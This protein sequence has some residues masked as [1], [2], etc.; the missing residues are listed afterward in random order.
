MTRD[1]SPARGCSLGR[2]CVS[3]FRPPRRGRRARRHSSWWRPRTSGAASPRSSPAT[4][5]R[6]REHHRQP[7]HRSASTSR[8][9]RRAR[10][11]PSRRLAIV[12]GI[13]YDNWASQLLAA[14]LRRPGRARR[15]RPARPRSRAT[16]RT[17]GTRRARVR[18]VI[19]GDRRR[20]RR[21]STRRTP[22]YFA[23]AGAPA[24]RRVALARY[25]AA[26]G[27]DPAPLRRGARRLQREHLP[28]ARREPRV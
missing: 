9:R 18:T 19:D 24:S 22:R 13:G 8:R 26:A 28:A 12:N 15:R 23:R 2:S 11:W 25:D 17:S 5:P 6:V 4:G 14:T 1:G 3:S 20:L 16:T 21:S 27:R 10:R 7:G